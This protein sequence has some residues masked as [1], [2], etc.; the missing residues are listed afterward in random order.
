MTRKSMLLA[1][2]AILSMAIPAIGNDPAQAQQQSD[3]VVEEVVVTGTYIRRPQQFGSASPISVIGREDITDIGA[4]T[5]ADITQTLTIN[6]GAQ[7]NPDAFTQNFSTGTTNINLRGLG[8][9]STLVL[10]NGHRQ[11]VSGAATDSGLLF[12]DTSSLVPMIAIERVEVL[13]DGAS[14]LYGSDAVAGVVNFITRDD[15][16]GFEVSADYQFNTEHEQDDI[17]VQAIGGMGDENT[18][19]MAAFSYFD[20]TALTTAEKRLPG[21]LDPVT[22]DFSNAGQPGT[23]ITPTRPGDPQSGALFDSLFD[24]AV[25]TFSATIPNPGIPGLPALLPAPGSTF[26]GFAPGADGIADALS[27]EVYAQIFSGLANALGI[28]PALLPFFTDIPPGAPTP[29]FADPNCAAGEN[30]VPPGPVTVDGEVVVP[31]GIVGLCRLD[32]GT[33][34]NLVPR[35]TRHQGFAQITHEFS[36]SMEFYGEFAFSRNRAFR[37]NTPSFPITTPI[38]IS[39]D[40]PFNPFG[41]DVLFVGRALGQGEPFQSTHFSDTWR[42]QAGIRGD[43]DFGWDYDLSYTRGINEFDLTAGDQ[44]ADEFVEALNGLGGPNCNALT[45]SPGVGACQFFNPFGSALTAAPGDTVPFETTDEFGNPVT[46]QVPLVNS[47]EIIND[48]TARLRADVESDLTVVDAVT[49]GD[50]AEIAGGRMVQAAIGFQFRESRLSQDFG[51]NANNNRFLFLVGNPDFAETRTVWAGFTELYVPLLEQLDLQLAVRYEDFSDGLGS[52][53]DPKAA[54]VYRY[55]D[56]FAL[57]GSFS[58]AFRAPSIFQTN[59]FQTTLAQLTDT[60]PGQ[61]STPQF[62]AVRTF[63]NPDLEPEES[64][65][66]NL[67]ATWEPGENLEFN[68]DYWR[69]DFTD[70]ITQENAQAILDADP[71]S[72]DILRGPGGALL[73]VN[74]DFVN[75]ASLETDGID[76]SAVY[77]HDAMEYGVIQL[78]GEGTYILNYDLVDPQLG[79]I[80]GAG[81]RNFRNFGTSA[82]EWR[83]NGRLSWL[84]GP[85]A[86]NLYVRYIDGY[87][88]DQNPGTNIDSH[89]TVDV[90]YSFEIPEDLGAMSGTLLTFGAIN[91]FDNNPPIVFTSGGFDSKV[92]D[93]RGRMVYARI[94]K[95]F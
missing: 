54:L 8:V 3:D 46:V 85:H 47:Q 25:P 5:I 22:G 95:G 16:T 24:N 73:Q 50:I 87:Q 36:D 93:P 17:R 33:F 45:G 2:T 71:L 52:T 29:A 53:I 62:K 34:F 66:Y 94:T 15:F 35:E 9:S 19:V 13:E 86:A 88:D 89:T 10:L 44:L 63:G 90:Q 74:A 84:M 80:E 57:R 92:H 58:T 61:P 78:A 4:K 56:E 14:A 28:D 26:T 27:A 7:N 67:G 51:E 68:I 1:T 37:N 69:F 49:S 21:S 12:V 23:F 91:L 60:L 42:V 55:N 77:S 30:S 75:A 83:L 76:F 31:P 18:H 6:T 72:P 59:G 70:V 48:V 11:V 65:A 64:E 40:N 20:R 43:F 39:E 79:A 41:T 81:R 38:P 32:F 82:P